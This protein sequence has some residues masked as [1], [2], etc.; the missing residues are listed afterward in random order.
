[1]LDRT[2]PLESIQELLNTITSGVC[3]FRV[4]ESGESGS[5]YIAVYF[6]DYAL[7]H[8]GKTL[9]QVRGKSLK[10]L[11]PTI[12]EYGLIQ[13]FRKV[14]ETGEPGFFPAKAYIDDGYSNCYE[15]RVFKL[16]GDT[17]VAVYDDVTERYAAL[18]ALRLS[19]ERLREVINTMEKAVAVFEPVKDAA[20]FRFVEANRFS[21]K[22][23]GYTIDQLL[24]KTIKELFPE[25]AF[26][27]LIAGLRECLET[28]E[29]VRIPLKRYK[30]NRIT[31]WVENTIF[32]LPTGNVVA[33]FEDT[34]T[35]RKM[36]EK[37]EE[38]RRT[39]QSYLENAPH[40]FFLADG[41]GNI[42]DVNRKAE[43]VTG[44]SRDELVS[45]KTGD[46]LQKGTTEEVFSRF[47]DVREKGYA[48]GELAI[49]KKTGERRIWSVRA[50]KL[51]GNRFMA[52]T[53]DVTE[54]LRLREEL[55]ENHDRFLLSERIGSMGSWEFNIRTSRLWGSE[56][57]R[58]ITGFDLNADSFTVD[59]LV[60]GIQ[61][62]ERVIQF[63]R[64]LAEEKSAPEIEFE[65]LPLD[66]ASPR[67]IAL[68]ARI[69][70][71]EKGKPLKITGTVQN[72][73]AMVEAEKD[74][75]ASE[76]K[77]HSLFANLRDA[78]AITDTERNLLDCNR[79]FL[80]MFRFS[81]E[82]VTGKS[83][84]RFYA[85][86]DQFEK[87]GK[88][89]AVIGKG[90]CDSFISAVFR[91]S[92][93]EEFPG[94]IMVHERKN[95]RGEIQGFTALIRDVSGRKLLEAQVRQSQKMEA[96]GQLASG[97]AHDFNNL[98]TV[99]N[100]Y[101]FM[102]LE[103]TTR[104]EKGWMELQ[105]I[106]KAGERAA[107]LTKQL[108]AFSRKQ[109]L[110][111]ER[112][113]LNARIM[114]AETLLRRIIGENILLE[115]RFQQES[116][117]AEVDPGQFDQIVMN[118]AVN[119]RD[120]MLRGG[121][122]VIET[123]LI[124][125]GSARLPEGLTPDGCFTA[126][127]FTDNGCGIPPEN[128]EHIFEPFFTTKGAGRGTGMGLPTVYGI[129]A[130]SGG[131]IR[132]KSRVD[133]GTRVSVYLPCADDLSRK[134]TRKSVP[135]AARSAGE[136][137]LV[138]EDEALVRDLLKT[139]LEL[140]GFSVTAVEGGEEALETLR[141]TSVLPRLLLTDVVMPGMSGRE[142]AGIVLKEYPDVSICFMSGYTDDTLETLGI[143][144][145]R[146]SFIH[147]PFLPRELAATIRRIL[148]QP[149]R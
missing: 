17:I 109:V 123:E 142:L 145:G 5:D 129:V 34:Y 20:D 90:G 113:D 126:T 43:E 3:V 62:S 101:A 51:P 29:T 85:D 112:I 124:H 30:D 116:I 36:E 131:E 59:N 93:G 122:L 103:V 83:L 75:K 77:Y 21:E 22:L 72:V 23:T 89:L 52:F 92:T 64:D 94:E 53:T 86:E 91:R 46:L 10:D 98:L 100:G 63:F 78:M 14:W 127:H 8:E 111:P 125:P 121:R 104:E 144:D 54:S 95:S 57:A 28:G 119:A 130:Q 117:T 67:S 120:A 147:K 44:Y 71:D 139:S 41:K 6:N 42:L 2:F 68:V 9:E 73:T 66:S 13:V 132:I 61:E 114:D 80:E 115:T 4:M 1:M 25:E 96:I 107:L 84:K 70:R 97:I 140:F 82:D 105:E 33:V 69:I 79:A 128:L 15:N 146:A 37:L 149:Q 11:R 65:I 135:P 106:R 39:L 35:Q 99:I 18:E 76:E 138:V 141:S 24:G 143:P 50:V 74:L 19:E 38:S 118:I 32:R 81:G 47:S 16:S 88:Y 40:A 110:K 137:V 136:P 58:R 102:L 45:M 26:V 49:T 133:E 31:Q 48:A 56:G 55:R 134:N 60:A 108:L 148:D 12:D 7:R 87:V 27:G